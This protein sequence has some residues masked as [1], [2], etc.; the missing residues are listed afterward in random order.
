VPV[1]AWSF[2]D[3]GPILLVLVVRSYEG[4]HIK[5]ILVED[6]GARE[7]PDMGMYLYQ[8]AF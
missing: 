3:H 5:P 8:C 7:L 6:N 1:A 4:V 2:A